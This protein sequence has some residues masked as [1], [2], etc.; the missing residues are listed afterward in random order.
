MP[1]AWPFGEPCP[2][3][4]LLADAPV[5]ADGPL[6]VADAPGLPD[7]PG[8]PD[9]PLADGEGWEWRPRLPARAGAVLELDG[10]GDSVVLDAV[11]EA[12][13][14]VAGVMTVLL[15]GLLLWAGLAEGSCNADADAAEPV[16]GGVGPRQRVAV[17]MAALSVVPLPDGAP[18]VPVGP[19]SGDPVGVGVGLGVGLAVVGVA[20]GE[21]AVG[22]TV[23][24]TAVPPDWPGAIVFALGMGLADVLQV[25]L[26]LGLA[27]VVPVPVFWPAGPVLPLGIFW[28]V[29]VPL[30][31]P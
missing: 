9:A 7:V 19:G 29:P 17:L 2:L 27:V 28:P 26:E 24:F 16:C 31:P 3:G 11:G 4:L 8:L 20:V 15:T 10:V 21:V 30:P 13:A 22:V 18:D 25:G 5:L 23:G 1:D 6:L 14:V 12:D